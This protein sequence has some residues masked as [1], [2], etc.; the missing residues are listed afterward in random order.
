MILTIVTSREA[1][2]REYAQIL[3]LDQIEIQTVTE[4]D[5]GHENVAGAAFHKALA[6]NAQINP[7]FFVEH[8]ALY[9]GHLGGWP[10]TATGRFL[11]RND[12]TRILQLMSDAL[13]GRRDAVAAVAIAYVGTAQSHP[14][15]H[16]A[17]VDGIITWELPGEHGFGWDTI[18]VPSGSD[19]TYAEMTPEKKDTM[20]MRYLAAA[21][22]GVRL[23]LDGVMPK[24]EGSRLL[25]TANSMATSIV[26]SVGKAAIS[27][28]VKHLVRHGYPVLL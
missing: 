11:A 8:T 18:F 17:T 1:K 15:V 19:V 22:F 23:E 24:G 6:A 5:P 16:S 20:S 2:R 25:S 26:I 3:Q 14:V 27:E 13:E 21:Q 9:I 28:G 12:P 4:S 7:P 10:G